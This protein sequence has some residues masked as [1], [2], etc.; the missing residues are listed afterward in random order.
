VIQVTSSN[1]AGRVKK[2][3]LKDLSVASTAKTEKMSSREWIRKQVV[4]VV[5][6][7]LNNFCIP[8]KKTQPVLGQA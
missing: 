1:P 6:L 5:P 4:F 8:K 2:L 7:V 3:S